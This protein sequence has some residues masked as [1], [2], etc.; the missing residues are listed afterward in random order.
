M[1]TVIAF[2]LLAGLACRPDKDAKV[3][4]HTNFGDMTVRLYNYT[5][6]HRD[7]FIRLAQTGFYD[8]LLFHRVM[9]DFMIQGGDPDSKTAPAGKVLGNGGPGYNISPEIGAPHIRG[10]LAAAR[11]PDA[12]NPGKRSNGSQ[13]FIVQGVS[14]TEASLQE[15]EQ[16]TGIQLEPSV[17]NL[18]LKR[19][20]AP[21][22]DGQYTVFGEVIEGLEVIDRI[23]AVPRDP[24]DRPLEDIRM[25]M[26]I[27]RQ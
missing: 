2:L 26:E 20:G 24:N 6:K 22:L 18:Y 8:S 17:R 15:L 27:R 7:N 19:G 9:L 10:A 16:Q 23:A 13:F 25:R 1:R 4:I 14:Q 3:V 12:L 11:F 5:P 21:F